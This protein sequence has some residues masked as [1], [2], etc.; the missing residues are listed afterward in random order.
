MRKILI[1]SH[2]LIWALTEPDK[3]QSA[4]KKLLESTS[5][6][7]IVSVAS[8]WELHIKASLNKLSLPDNLFDVLDENM[9]SIIPVKR[10]HLAELMNLPHHHR[11]PFDRLLIAQSVAENFPILSYDSIFQNYPVEM[12]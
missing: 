11:D 6:D 3:L 8:L 12:M 7:I 1:D 9:I 10:E 5:N 2:I 4:H